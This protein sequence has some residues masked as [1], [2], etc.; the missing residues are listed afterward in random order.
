MKVHDINKIRN[1]KTA[2]VK[3]MSDRFVEIDIDKILN[4]DAE[5]RELI[6]ELQELQSIRNTLSKSVPGLTKNKTEMN[7]LIEK[8]NKVKMDIKIKEEN[9]EVKSKSLEAILLNLPNLPSPDTPVGKNETFNK[10]I[11]ESKNFEKKDNGFSHDEIGANLNMMDFEAAAKISGS[12]FVILKSKLARLERALCNFMVDLHVKEHGYLEVSTPHLIKNN[13]LVGTGQLPKFEEDLFSVSSDK[14]LIPTAEVTLTNLKQGEI[15][16]EEELPLRYVALTNCFRSEAGASG[17]DTKGMIRLHEFKKVELVSIVTKDHSKEELERL[18]NCAKKV[19]ELLRIPYR[20]SLLCSGDMGFSASKTFDIEAWLPSQ[21]K[22]RE[23]S[24]CSNCKDFQTR[25][26]NTR[27]RNNNNDK[28]FPHS[29]NGSGLAVG[30]TL[31]AII[32]NYQINKNTVK[33]PE[34]LVKYMDGIE[35]I[36]L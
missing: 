12:R 8:V 29:L 19:L 36:E 32:E 2:F 4:L 6:Y 1:D 3:S 11:F 7:K 26:M 35:K 24:S 33:I 21:K 17:K 25:R 30:R 28:F 10:V 20:V 5:K 9:L 31:V 15:I 13:S 14:W 18:T 27:Y 34:V 22:Y 23:I 16:N